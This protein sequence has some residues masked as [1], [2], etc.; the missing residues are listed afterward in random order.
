VII[1]FVLGA[2]LLFGGS[3]LLLY[4]ERIQLRL[5]AHHEAMKR[6]QK[7]SH[8]RLK[9]TSMN[10]ELPLRALGGVLVLLFLILVID[11]GVR[12]ENYR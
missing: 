6:T 5:N 2:I 9:L 1:R 8:L 7:A 10:C 11:T 4:A 12:L 3:W